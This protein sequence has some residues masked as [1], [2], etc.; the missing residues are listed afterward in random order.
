[1]IRSKANDVVADLEMY[2]LQSPT[3]KRQG[4]VN[5]LNTLLADESVLYIKLRN[6]YWN[7][8]DVNM[9]TFQAVFEEQFNEIAELSKVTAAHISKYGANALG[10]MSE[11]ISRTHL[12]EEP[13]MYPDAQTMIENIVTDHET[14]IH[15]LHKD[16][17][18]FTSECE[19]M[20]VNDLLTHFLQQHKLM[21]ARL[22]LYLEG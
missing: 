22:R 14:I 9:Y 10:T 7:V 15:F 12:F 20:C 6:Y 16:I 1:M 11:F 4:V 8:T 17:E 2:P 5:V 21:A 3:F 18:T 13:G 19:D